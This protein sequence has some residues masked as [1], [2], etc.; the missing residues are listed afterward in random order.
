M[1]DEALRDVI[2][3]NAYESVSNFEEKLVADKWN[4]LVKKLLIV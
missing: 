3:K 1:N 4:E 2:G